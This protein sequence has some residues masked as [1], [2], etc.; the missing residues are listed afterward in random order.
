MGVGAAAAVT[1]FQVITWSEREATD[2]RN[3][4][5]KTDVHPIVKAGKEQI[6]PNGKKLAFEELMDKT[7]TAEFD[8]PVV[9]AAVR[10]VGI[11]E[12]MLE[13]SYCDVPMESR[14][15]EKVD[16]VWKSWGWFS[17]HKS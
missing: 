7:E 3:V 12:T 13:E 4:A 2:E 10:D 1:A 16:S 9:S 11:L 5:E 6:P 15:I 17:N 8:K 14:P